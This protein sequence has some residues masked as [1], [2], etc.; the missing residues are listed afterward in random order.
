MPA[1]R[2]VLLVRRGS[3]AGRAIVSAVERTGPDAPTSR[4]EVQWLSTSE[5]EDV[6]WDRSASDPVPDVVLET[7]VADEMAGVY[8]ESD[9]DEIW[10][11]L[12]GAPPVECQHAQQAGSRSIR[13][14]ALR[15]LLTLGRR[16]AYLAAAA[17]AAG[18]F[19]GAWVSTQLHRNMSD[20]IEQL[21]QV[22][23]ELQRELAGNHRDP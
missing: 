2:R 4:P 17:F 20:E 9:L 13:P 15:S 12:T 19:S 23:D 6:A 14:I 18:V 3:V 22:I 8:S 16:A 7:I 11:L 21:E 10:R 5:M 1:I